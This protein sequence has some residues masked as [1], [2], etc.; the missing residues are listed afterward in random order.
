MP[1][2]WGGLRGGWMCIDGYVDGM[3]FF[4]NLSR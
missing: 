4:K 3:K 1:V 2:F